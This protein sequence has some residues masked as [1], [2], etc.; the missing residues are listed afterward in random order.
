M[1]KVLLL[2]VFFLTSH[3]FV[4]QTFSTQ[5]QK[6]L[7]GMVLFLPPKLGESVI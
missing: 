6:S 3:W 7:E 1:K 5:W 2:I 4:A